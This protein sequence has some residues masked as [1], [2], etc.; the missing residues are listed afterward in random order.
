MLTRLEIDG[1][2]TFENLVIDLLPFTVVLGSNAAG[3]SNLFDAIRL[4]SLLA[5]RDVAEA[6]KDM[7]GE[8]LELFRLTPSGRCKQIH[9]AA[10]VL[11]DPMVRDPWGSEVKLS[12]T[13]MRY[14]VTLERREV[15]PGVERIQV[16]REQVLP[17]MRK[18][19][20]WAQAVKPSKDFR[21]TYLKYIRQKPWLT[22]RSSCSVWCPNASCKPRRGSDCST[23]RGT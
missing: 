15:R 3:K 11:V 10:E 19:D 9:M 5:T 18:D 21:A 6:V 23:L 22:Q 2:K 1:F 14:E 16:A 20:P 13:R 8:P 4:L 7:R 17:I 12:H